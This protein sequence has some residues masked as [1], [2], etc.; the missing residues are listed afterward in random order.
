MA[1]AS[2]LLAWLALV[3]PQGEHG[4]STPAAASSQA[5]FVT[6]AKCVSCHAEEGDLWRG[7]HHDLAMQ[8]VS[9]SSVLGDFSG[10][11]LEHFGVTT[12]FERKD[13]R[14]VV[15]TDG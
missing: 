11:S 13:D 4:A 12:T 2:T 3:L 7:S 6:S 1:L 15:R 10:A 5:T 14:W 8:T 9:A